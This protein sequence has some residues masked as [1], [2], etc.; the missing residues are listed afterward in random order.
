MLEQLRRLHEIGA[1]MARTHDEEA[2]L[3]LAV[4]AAKELTGATYTSLAFV[5]GDRLHWQ[6]AAG[7]PI[8]E[9]KGVKQP[10]SEGLCGWVV[11]HGRSRRSGDVTQEPDYY[12]Q[13]AEMRSELDVPILRGDR[14]IGVLNGESPETGVFTVEHEALIQVLAVYVSIAV[15][16]GG[17]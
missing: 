9:V 11:R 2:L 13:Y 3:H 5:E 17:K 16:H 7:K 6:S 15:C 12:L 1:E 10:V 14:V 4:S 8:E